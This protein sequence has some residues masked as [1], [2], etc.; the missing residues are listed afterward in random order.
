MGRG[1]NWFTSTQALVMQTFGRGRAALRR[2]IISY[3]TDYT[4]TFG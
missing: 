2:E 3:L 1:L 4:P